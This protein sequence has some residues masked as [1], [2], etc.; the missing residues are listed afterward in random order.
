MENDILKQAALIYGMK[1][2][3]IRQNSHKYSISAMC[4][5]LNVPRS[6][7][8]YKPSPSKP[9]TVMPSYQSSER[10]EINRESDKALVSI[11]GLRN[12]KRNC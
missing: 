7:F 3:I 5:T 1:I 10:A 6:T 12:C 11:S 8:Y 2:R 4:K 9:D